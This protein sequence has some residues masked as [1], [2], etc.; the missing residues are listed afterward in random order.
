MNK[1]HHNN[2]QL[3]DSQPKTILTQIHR[4][5]QCEV[6]SDERSA[7]KE[8]GFQA[9]LLS[10]GWLRFKQQLQKLT[11]PGLFALSSLFLPH[12][13]ATE[14]SV[15]VQGQIQPGLYGQIQVGPPAITVIQQP[16][17]RQ[18]VYVKSTYARPVYVQ[19]PVYVQPILVQASKKHRKHWKKYCHHYGACQQQ[20]QF[21]E[22]D[23]RPRQYEKVYVYQ[24]PEHGYRE[25]KHR[26]HHRRH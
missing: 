3:T 24:A 18:P 21:V 1:I 8:Q 2:A 4:V 23:Y 19:Q 20:V 17:Y 11:I 13:Q 14:V 26:G 22:V 6:R 9:N 10:R 25:E 5:V 16:V 15:S 7:P 12:A